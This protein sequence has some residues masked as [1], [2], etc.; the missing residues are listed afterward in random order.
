M[1]SHH[2]IAS[3]LVLGLL[4]L[5][6]LRLGLGSKKGLGDPLQLAGVQGRAERTVTFVNILGFLAGFSV[7]WCSQSPLSA[8]PLP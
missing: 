3:A 5:A 6:S 4:R 1:P 7:G 8:T 2:R